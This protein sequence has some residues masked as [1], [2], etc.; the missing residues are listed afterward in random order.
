MAAT[1]RRNA[2]HLALHR[3]CRWDER[4]LWCLRCLRSTWWS[5]KP[6]RKST[7]PSTLVG[8]LEK[9]ADLILF[10]IPHLLQVTK[11]LDHLLT[12]ACHHSA[13][14]IQLLAAKK[15]PCGCMWL[16]NIHKCH[17]KQAS[18]LLVQTHK[19][20]S[21]ILRPTN[22]V[23]CHDLWK[24]VDNP[25]F[26]VWLYHITHTKKQ[27]PVVQSQKGHINLSP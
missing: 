16:L 15:M 7:L 21:I 25:L 2:L 18:G 22:I 8:A 23:K 14:K 5:W 17:Q 3:C 12:S 24:A 19:N 26:I 9:K 27:R 4:S 13:G 1:C 11:W 10:L 6:G 20:V